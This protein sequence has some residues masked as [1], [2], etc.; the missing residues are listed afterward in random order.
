[1]TKLQKIICLSGS[2]LLQSQLVSAHAHLVESQPAKD[3]VVVIAPTEVR[4]KFSE[5]L[6]FTMSKIEV[7]NVATHE[8]VSQN[9]KAG[10]KDKKILITT[11]N[12][13]KNEKASYQVSWKA[14]TKDSHTMKG[15]YIFI[16]NPSNQK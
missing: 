11:L 15:T 13:L 16:F 4:A 3:E 7:Q 1:M 12:P 5:D 9:A 6:E 8:V 14:V 2:I 10:E